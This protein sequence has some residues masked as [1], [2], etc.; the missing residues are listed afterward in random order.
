[1]RNASR[2]DGDGVP[3][4]NSPGTPG[5]GKKKKKKRK[6]DKVVS[7]N[8]GIGPPTRP[9]PAVVDVDRSAGIGHWKT[10]NKGALRIFSEQFLLYVY[11][12]GSGASRFD[13]RVSFD[14]NLAALCHVAIE[15]RG[16]K[17]RSACE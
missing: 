5:G 12:V 15:A 7:S 1:M 2:V 3:Y 17:R 8:P 11:Y 4:A 16:E 14:V 9:P 6:A 13:V 10:L